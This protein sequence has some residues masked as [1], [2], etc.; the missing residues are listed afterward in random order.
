[1]AETRF[2][3]LVD[4]IIVS[5]LLWLGITWI[6]KS[7]A[8]LALPGII[9]LGGLYFLVQQL[10]LQLTTWIFQGFFAAFVL[11]IVIVFQEDLRRLFEHLS[12]WGMR[13]Q[14]PLPRRAI[15]DII[16]RA[17]TRLMQDKI[18]ALI[19]I[20][21]RE[22]LERHLDGGVELHGQASEPLLLSLFDPGTPG[23]DGAV[24]F[25][26][27]KIAL[28]SVHLPLSTD[29][30]NFGQRG[31]RHASAL[32]LTERNDA[33]CIVV[34][35]EKGTLSVAERGLLTPLMNPEALRREINAFIQK[36]SPRF[37]QADGLQ[38]SLRR[39]ASKWREGIISFGLAS[40]IW[41]FSVPGTTVIEFEK[42]LPVVIKNLPEDY[43][44]QDVTPRKTTVTLRGQRR[45][46]FVSSQNRFQVELDASI[47]NLGRRTF[48][49]SPEVVSHPQSLEVIGIQ[50]ESIRLTV[51][52]REN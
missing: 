12:A 13:R 8:R 2:F 6:R 14:A 24:I 32:G 35:E 29:R 43:I 27:D 38:A 51:T 36:R 49:L 40:A 41:Y 44:L 47:V 45:T 48:Q 33:L 23:H 25:R 34:S 5:V 52:K 21:G 18:G 3:Y 50:P 22:P 7:H 16:V 39:I 11:V 37:A 20:P 15:A 17:V 10:R 46:Y 9:I 1:M 26:G 19:V 28:F 4:I 30:G 42:S 31:T